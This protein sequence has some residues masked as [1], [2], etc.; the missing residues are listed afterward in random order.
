M[1]EEDNS[2]IDY[3]QDEAMP[4]KEYD[5]KTKQYTHPDF[6]E[7]EGN[8]LRLEESYFS[9]VAPAEGD[10]GHEPQQFYNP[11]QGNMQRIESYDDYTRGIKA[12]QQIPYLKGP[13]RTSINNESFPELDNGGN[14]QGADVESIKMVEVDV[15]NFEQ[16]FKKKPRL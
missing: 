12:K 9:N 6:D 16:N 11:S 10:L 2:S 13:S 3:D 7:P 8:N 14:L 1:L 5:P 4:Y 15:N